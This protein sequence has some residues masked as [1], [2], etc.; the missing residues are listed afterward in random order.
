MYALKIPLQRRPYRATGLGPKLRS[1][2]PAPHVAASIMILV[3]AGCG[4]TQS[5]YQE[6]VLTDSGEPA[7]VTVQ[8]CLI[9]FRDIEQTGALRSLEEA[10]QLAGEILERARQGEDF[11]NIVRRHTDDSYPGIYQMA[12]H[13]FDF[14]T[15]SVVPSKQIYSRDG[16]A[17]DF[18]NVSFAL[19]V[20]EIGMAAYDERLSPYGWHIIKRLK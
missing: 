4:G 10:E 17:Q 13:G 5:L 18:G 14:D 7:Y 1:M 8:H 16:M 2:C 20:G 9:S 12:N 11:G 19:D 6:N 3:V 15:S